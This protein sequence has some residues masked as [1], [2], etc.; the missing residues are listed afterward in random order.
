MSVS[1]TEQLF[2]TRDLL[3]NPLPNNP[4]FHQLLRQEI[5]T[6]MD[7][8]NATNNSS[9]PWALSTYQL[10]YIVGQ[11]TYAINV[12]DFGKVMYVERVQGDPYIRY[13]NVP[14]SD[15]HDLDYG[16]IWQYTSGSF[17][18]V[19]WITETPERMAFYRDGVLNSQYMVRIQPQPIQSWTYIIHYMPGVLA[20]TD[21]L[22]SAVQLPEHATLAQLRNAT[23]LLPY[24]QWGDD[25]VEND[26]IRKR[27]AAGFEYQ[28]NIKEPLFR[29]YIK[30][31]AIPKPVFLEEWN[32]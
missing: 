23:A 28:L 25:K 13:V 12:S 30:S 31:I 24:A 7:I 2:R 29:T 17:G 22:A 18:Q 15:V 5:S 32:S 1:R 10:N 21:P 20:N 16:T 27:L 26:N 9:K 3:D 4:S 11:D 14:F 19:P 6:E 8:L